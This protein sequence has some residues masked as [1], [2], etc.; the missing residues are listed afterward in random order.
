MIIFTDKFLEDWQGGRQI[1][2]MGLVRPK[3]RNDAA[4]IQHEREHIRQWW[5]CLCLGLLPCVAY[6]AHTMTYGGFMQ[7][8]ALF[9][10]SA[11]I[12]AHALLYYF[13]KS[14]RL[15]AEVRAYK[16]SLKY[17]PQMI[18]QYAKHISQKYNLDVSISEAKIRLLS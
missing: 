3:Y 12:S 13:S 9:L 5:M 1:M 16:E 7:Q 18:D 14:Y 15:W 11:S 4:I 10:F 2:F 6:T 17:K 8:V